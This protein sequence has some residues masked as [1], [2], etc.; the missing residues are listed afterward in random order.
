MTGFHR[1]GT[2]ADVSLW[3]SSLTGEA[4]GAAPPAAA[5]LASH[6]DVAAGKPRR[7]LTPMTC[8]RDE[9]EHAVTDE[10]IADALHRNSGVYRA[11]CGH[12]I[13]PQ[14]LA[15]PPG[16]PCTQCCATVSSSL[17]PVPTRAR[18]LRWTSA[19]RALFAGWRPAS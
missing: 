16:W 10:E 18:W 9:A 3:R 6:L 17:R 15:S 19:I 12:A 13:T 8:S 7:W 2:A 11:V 5:G 1:A 14:A 4:G